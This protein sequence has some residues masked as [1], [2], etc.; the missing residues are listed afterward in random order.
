MG[1]ESVVLRYDFK[2]ELDGKYR[3]LIVKEGGG[4][5]DGNWRNII[6]PKMGS[7]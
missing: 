3:V 5:F 6:M 7:A 1:V 2:R 4:I